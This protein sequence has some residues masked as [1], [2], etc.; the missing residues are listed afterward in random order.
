VQKSL[1]V[2]DG[3]CES[4]RPN[5]GGVAIE[6]HHVAAPRRA[7]SKDEH[8]C[9][10]PRPQLQKVVAG[11]AQEAGEIEI[12]CLE[13]GSARLG[14]SWTACSVDTL[15]SPQKKGSRAIGQKPLKRHRA[16][17][18]PQLFE[19]DAHGDRRD[20]ELLGEGLGEAL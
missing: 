16:V 3:G 9:A 7:I 10:G 11:A 14:L 6:G 13:R 1:H 5:A 19:P 17:Q 18:Q 2:L 15:R 4:Q 12:A 20:E 8:L